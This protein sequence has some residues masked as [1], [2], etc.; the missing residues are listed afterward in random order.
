MR[1]GSSGRR[2]WCRTVADVLGARSR[3]SRRPSD[4]SA[5][6]IDQPQGMSITSR[7]IASLPM[8]SPVRRRVATESSP[9]RSSSFRLRE[10]RERVMRSWEAAPRRRRPGEPVGSCR[11][12]A[13]R[14]LPLADRHQRAFSVDRPAPQGEVQPPRPVPQAR[15]PKPSAGPGRATRS[16]R[17]QGEVRR[18]RGAEGRGRQTAPRGRPAHD[19]LTI[20]AR[21]AT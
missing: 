16:A 10:R 7:S 18:R 17:S 5:R 20:L 13:G 12:K 19:C 8:I 21:S 2:T 3:A 6:G 11:S 14:R 15:D 1:T 4:G 9:R